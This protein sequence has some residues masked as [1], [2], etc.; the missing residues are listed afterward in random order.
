MTVAVGARPSAEGVAPS[1]TQRVPPGAGR[2]RRLPAWARTFGSH[3]GV[4]GIFSVPAFFLWWR[5]WTSGS[6]STLRCPCLDP[7]QQVWFVAW[8]AYAISHGIDPFFSNWLWPPHGVNLLDNASGPLIGIVLSPITWLFGPF[9][10]TTLGLTLAPALSAWGCWLACRRFVT[11]T[12]AS[13]VAGFLFGYSP[14]VV[15]NVAQGHLSVGLLV[16]PPLIVLALHEI[17]VRQE[18]PPVQSGAALGV[19]L[20]L[21]FLVSAEVLTVTV[22]VA[23]L[24]CVLA[25]LISPHRVP[26]AFPYA[27]RAVGF[28]A[29]TAVVLLAL[30]VWELMKGPQHIS[31]SIWSGLQ[32]FLTGRAYNLWSPGSYHNILWGHA[33]TGPSPEY[34]GIG[35]L[36]VAILSLAVAARRRSAWVIG[37]AAALA[38]VLSW[39][40]LLWL[41]PGH[42][43]VSNW[44]PWG[45]FLSL[46]VFQNLSP[47][48]FAVAADLAVALLIGIGMD[49][50]RWSSLGSRLGRFGRSA[51]MIAVV[52]AMGLPIWLTYAAPFT[53]EGLQLP[54]WYATVG[55]Q[56]P[57]G[58]VVV[59]YP[60]P[61]SL[62]VVSSPMDWQAA[63]GMRFRLAGGYAKVPAVHG[64]KGVLKLGGP[65][66]PLWALFK[67]SFIYGIPK[68]GTLLTPT[69]LAGLR[70]DLRTWHTSYIVVTDQG[71]ATEAAALFTAATGRTP[72]ISHRSWVW[73]LHRQP[74]GPDAEWNATTAVRAFSSC[75]ND[76]IWLPGVGPP[77][78]LPQSYNRCIVSDMTTST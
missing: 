32:A 30:P 12:P 59:S 67:L 31:G 25:A 44:L 17:L 20:F 27:A 71:L 29:L 15:Q 10:A 36:V 21:Q 28:G 4:I 9:V 1:D 68:H 23:A 26:S 76:V 2:Q 74:L 35:V 57:E 72:T 61:A 51:A 64:G 77:L 47:K 56:V 42:V 19:L 41:S 62:S 52:L 11:W 7:G 3:L 8:P 78:A 5:A 37:G 14:V 73:D 33:R 60:F 22:V 58:S 69:A 54:P 6:A 40:S 48:T 38:T 24:G 66:Q 18:R 65:D 16:F 53:V 70:S 63:D 45:H 13:W 34:L 43:I 75:T 49:A 55:R 46:P 50:A 39:G